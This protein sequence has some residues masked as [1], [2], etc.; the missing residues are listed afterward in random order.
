MNH[1]TWVATLKLDGEGKASGQ[2]DWKLLANS[3]NYQHDNQTYNLDKLTANLTTRGNILTLD[4]LSLPP[5]AAY[6]KW[7]RGLLSAAGKYD[8]KIKP[9]MPTFQVQ[10][11]LSS[12]ELQNPWILSSMLRATV[13]VR[14]SQQFFLDGK[15]LRLWANGEIAYA[16]GTPVEL[17][18][19]GWYPPVDYT[20][21][22]RGEGERENVHLSG[23]LWSELLL[24]RTPG[25]SISTSPAR[26]MARASTLKITR[27]AM[28]PLNS[29]ATPIRPTFTWA[30]PK[31]SY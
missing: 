25:L 16:A 18:L 24:K 3:L 27:S 19:F 13:P 23:H 7:Q 21:H 17:Y 30:L 20:W 28:S 10:A 14:I 15:E 9:G 8:L 1:D 4:S 2:I 31:W 26:S 12:P 29:K 5:G 6:G 11:G 22:E